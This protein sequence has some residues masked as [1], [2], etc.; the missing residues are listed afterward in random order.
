MRHAFLYIFV[1]MKSK[2]YKGAV[3]TYLLQLLK[4]NG[5]MYGY[6]IS[7][8]I[9]EF[10]N[11]ELEIPESKLYP[12]LHKM[13]SEGFLDVEI[14]SAGS[15]LRKYYKLT[16]KGVKS[17]EDNLAELK[18]FIDNLSNLMNPQFS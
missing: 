1:S 4:N 11:G 16:G 9:K 8:K 10:T 14:D 17:S 2:L 18:A 13:E 6:E 7:K 15:R 5:R 3:E 12:A